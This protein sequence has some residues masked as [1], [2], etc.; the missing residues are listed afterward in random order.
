[1]K[2]KMGYMS[3][4]AAVLLILTSLSSVIG[5][6]ASS[7]NQ[8]SVSPLFAVRTARSNQQQQTMNIQCMYLGKGRSATLFPASSLTLQS[9]LDKAI[10]IIQ[11]NPGLVKKLLEK[12]SDAPQIIKIFTQYGVSVPDVQRYITQVK[13]NPELLKDQLKDV[14][15]ALKPGSDVPRPLGLDTSSAIGCFITV[16]VLLPLAIVLGILIATITLVTC[17][18][19]GG[20]AE[21]I[22]AAILQSIVQGLTPPK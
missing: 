15:F 18:N 12:I 1:M 6:T 20:C 2:K 11:N 17:L 8:Q 13:D 7:Q 10:K 4:G 14:D 9:Q 19:I 5:F 16:L 3:I 21:T 22:I